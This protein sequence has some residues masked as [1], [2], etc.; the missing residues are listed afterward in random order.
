MG[1]VIN[2]YSNPKVSYNGV[3]TGSKTQNCARVIKENRFAFAAVGDESGTCSSMPTTAATTTTTTTTTTIT[4]TITTTTTT[5]TA[6]DSEGTDGGEG[7]FTG[8]GVWED[9]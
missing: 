1:K 5:T 7:E 8:E 6:T 3:P 9:N 4:T 2:Y